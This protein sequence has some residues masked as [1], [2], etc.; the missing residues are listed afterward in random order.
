[1]TKRSPGRTGGGVSEIFGEEI[2]MRG[3]IA[4]GR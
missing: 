4:K 1:M 2:V 3:E